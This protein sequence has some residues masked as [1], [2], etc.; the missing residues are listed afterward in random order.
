MQLAIICACAPSIRLL[1]VSAFEHLLNFSRQHRQREDSEQTP[2]TLRD[3]LVVMQ[4]RR[5]IQTIYI[6]YHPEPEPKTL[7]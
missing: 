6:S 7:A 3:E 2:V 1:Y 4:S 5:S